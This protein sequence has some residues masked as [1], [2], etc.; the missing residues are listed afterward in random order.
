MALPSLI[1]ESSSSDS[2]ERWIKQVSNILEK[3]VMIDI[4]VPVSIFRVPATLSA[5][6]PQAYV[7]RLVAL[8]PYHH[9]RS[10]LYEMERYKLA[11]AGR[12]QKQFQSIKF[13]QLV[14]M[15]GELEQEVRACYHKYLDIEG[16]TLSWIMAIDGLFLIDFLYLFT[17]RKE[18][19]LSSAKAHLVDSGGKKLASDA[20][21]GDVLMLENQVPFFVLSKVLSFH[22]LVPELTDTVLPSILM[23]FCKALSP[24]KLKEDVPLSEV[25]KRPHLLDL[26]HHLTVPKLEVAHEY[27]SIYGEDDCSLKFS[28]DSHHVFTHLWEFFSRL[29]VGFL[30]KIIKPIKMIISVPLKIVSRVPELSNLASKNKEDTKPEGEDKKESTPMVEEIIIPSVS[31][32]CDIGIKFCPT[33]RGITSIKFDRKKKIIYLPVITLDVHSEVIMRNLVAY[34]A[35]VLSECL[36]FTRYTELMNGIIDT[37]EDA[38]LL[39]EKNIIVHHLKSDGE[40]AQFFNGMSK[41][42]RL[43][44][45]PYIDKVI[46]DV[47]KTYRDTPKVRVRE[48]TKMYVYRS[49]KLLTLLGVLCLMLLVAL[50]SFCSI[51]NCPR[52]FNTVSGTNA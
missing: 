3:E 48:C 44:H 11:A 40:V 25:L 14:D 22:C 1:F 17:S 51:Y 50:Q 42:I 31:Q 43:T 19:D 15:L 26:L 21:L 35:S 28:D 38:K 18:T 5:F 39:R 41:C 6:K 27:C 52:I 8:G 29:E 9:F 32:L 47:T 45:V 16:H 37:I 33:S 49:W 4:Q 2:E 24:L 20:I 10:E 13:Q 30:E 46:E 12:L 34:E 7:P 36:V 23:D